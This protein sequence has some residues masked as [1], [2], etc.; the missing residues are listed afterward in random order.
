[1]IVNAIASVADVYVLDKE[2]DDDHNRSVITFVGDPHDVEEAAFRGADVAS[3]LIDL[4]YHQGEH[5]R[6]GAL[7]VLPFVPI[8]GV[9]MDECVEIARRVGERIANELRIPVY[10]YDKAALNPD[11][12]DLA[13][14][15][16]GEFEAL[17]TLIETDPSRKPDFGDT[18]IHP[19][20]GAMAV[21]ARN[22]LVAYNIN[23]NTDDLAIAKKISKAVRGSSGGLKYVKALGFRLR[24][25]G[26]VQVSMN[27]VNYE[28]TPMFRVFDMV[29]REAERY[30]ITIA[31][32]EIIGLAPQAALNASS[33]HYLQIEN[34]SDNLILDNR[35]RTELLRSVVD[36]DFFSKFKADSDRKTRIA[37]HSKAEAVKANAAQANSGASQSSQ[38]TPAIQGSR[39]YPGLPDESA[40]SPIT[41]NG[42]GA[43]ANV[44]SIGASLGAM[45]CNLT[46][47]QKPVLEP[48]LSGV[49]DQLEQLSEDLKREIDLEQRT[50]TRMMEAMALPHKTDAD[51]L[52][53]MMAIEEASKYAVAVPQRIAQYATEVLE[54]MSELSEIGNPTYFADL[55]AGTQL[56]FAAIKSA[57]YDIFSLLSLIKND[58]DFKRARR[59]EINELITRGR[60]KADEIETLFFRVY[61]Q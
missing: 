3:N 38:T 14:V 27:L 17:R 20:A 29:K 61:P 22:I 54:L 6:I 43:A 55:A 8:R 28:A 23:L 11:R 58:E 44:G 2:M 45:V 34:Y 53:K 21:G 47:K 33:E 42:G 13:Y 46:L 15:R 39:V 41:P 19:T 32:S 37:E 25:R 48:E 60:E 7:D 9:T 49:L 31:G 52:A 26:I 24:K 16:R 5:P 56:A 10:L 1:M 18:K 35:L 40:K 59:A 57:S 51:K 4:N 36:P 50:S 12:T 30:G